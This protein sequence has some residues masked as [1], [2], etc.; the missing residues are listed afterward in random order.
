MKDLLH[1]YLELN[2]VLPFYQKEKLT[3]L[4]ELVEQFNDEFNTN[5]DPINSALEYMSHA[6]KFQS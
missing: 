4:Q 6:S 3:E 5:F 2:S 1:S